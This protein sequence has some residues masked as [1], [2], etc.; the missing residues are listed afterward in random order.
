[1]RVTK[2]ACGRSSYAIALLIAL[3]LAGCSSSTT[4]LIVPNPTVPTG[5]PTP[6]APGPVNTYTGGQS[7]GAWSFTLNHNNNTFSYQPVTYP[8]AATSGA[9]QSTG[10]FIGLGE[11]GLAYEALGQAAVL[12]PGSSSA[13]AVFTVPQSQCYPIAGRLRFQYIAMFPGVEESGNLDTSF[14]APFLGYGSVV[15][16]TGTDGSSWQFQNLQGGTWTPAEGTSSNLVAGPASFSGTCSTSNGQASIR[17]TSTSV[18]D[19]FWSPAGASYTSTTQSTIWVGPS[20]FFAADQSDPTQTTPTGASVA[21]MAEPSAPLSTSAVA[22]AQYLGVLYEASNTYGYSTG[23]P[24]SPAYTVPVGFGQ[25]VA[26]TGNTMTGGVFANDNVTGTPNS[27]IQVNL[28]SQDSALNGLYTAASITVPDPAQNCANFTYLSL[29]GIVS[30]GVNAQGYPTCTFPGVAVA[31]NPDGNY[32]V[33]INSYDW[34]VRYGGAP[35]QIYLFQQ[36]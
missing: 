4:P 13:S 32:A 26:G 29:S 21:G 1:M 33:F 10:G 11:A 30:S 15:A 3:V 27:D 19:T 31:G 18:L 23:V 9:I 25:V 24:A 2:D 17:L 7:P 16:S 14:G 5:L 34:A 12:R 22:S 8:V 28:G 20:G 35:M 36:N 6:A